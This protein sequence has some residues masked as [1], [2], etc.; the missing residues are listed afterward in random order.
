MASTGSRLT[1]AILALFATLAWHGIAAAFDVVHFETAVLPPLDDQHGQ[2]AQG[3]FPIWGHLSHPDD[4][5]RFP[6]I[7]LMHGCGGLQ[8]AHFTWADR[9]NRLGYITLIVDSFRPRSVVRVCTSGA[10]P[11]A[12][13]QRVLD[14]H[15][16]LAYLRDLPSVDPEH[17]GIIGWSHG[18]IAALEAVNAKGISGRFRH[19]FRAAAGFYPYCIADRDFDLPVLILIGD[20]DDWTPPGLCQRLAERNHASG[21]LELVIYPGAFHGFDNAGF[22][23]GFS[24]RGAGG[25]SHRLQ[26][27]ADARRDAAQRLGDFFAEHLAGN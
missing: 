16:A 3:G 25:A 14:A 13:A 4:E 7:V 19:R 24:V 26:Y 11:T 15:G 27:D 5:G 17:I 20:A 8:Q 2:T 22:R 6:A 9:L 21:Q 12:P 18:G 10:R 23:R 1:A